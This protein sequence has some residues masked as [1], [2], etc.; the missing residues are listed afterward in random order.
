[1]QSDA[2]KGEFENSLA[3]LEES[4]SKL[5]GRYEQIQLSQQQQAKLLQELPEI[6][7]LPEMVQQ[8]VVLKEELQIL[9]VTL[10]SSLLNDDQLRR[11][12]WQAVKNGLLGDVFWQILRFG[13]IGL[14][15]GWLLKSFS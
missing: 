5:K 10:E 3:E 15:I 7:P 12:F 9:E 13:T 8:V 4:L 14:I 6:E 2:S 1:M 11:L